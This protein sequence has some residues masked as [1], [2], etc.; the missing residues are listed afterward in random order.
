MIFYFHVNVTHVI[1]LSKQ[2]HIKHLLLNV[3]YLNVCSGSGLH[4]HGDKEP[5]GEVDDWG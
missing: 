2:N 5:G 4:N 1:S 3:V